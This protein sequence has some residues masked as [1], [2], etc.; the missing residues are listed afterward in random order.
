M[1]GWPGEMHQDPQSLVP[2]AQ[3]ISEGCILREQDEEEPVD[4][5]L[6]G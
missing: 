5:S 2:E 4:A 6:G 3:D 1:I